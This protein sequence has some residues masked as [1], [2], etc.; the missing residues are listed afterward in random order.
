MTFLL[1]PVRTVA[2]A[3]DLITLDEAKE[4]LRVLHTDH[5]S[6]ITALR[7]A[8][9]AHLDGW[10]G[11]L[12]RCLITQTWRQDLTRW[13]G[14]VRLPFPDVQSIG[15]IVYSD[16]DNVEQTVASSLYELLADDLGTYVHF[17]DGF[18]SPALYADRS[19]VVRI[20]FDAG[21]GAAAT[22]V[23]A[24]IVHAAHVLIAHW[25]RQRDAL[26]DPNINALIAKHRHRRV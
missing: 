12:G 19:D 24:D 13:S 2:P 4:N 22:A 7:D 25:Y 11:I 23:P 1:T 20:T 21:F 6:R 26:G 14:V 3:A 10:S 18:T 16:A 9:V 5:D 17:L 15:S 8:A